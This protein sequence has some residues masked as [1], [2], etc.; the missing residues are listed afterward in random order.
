[1]PGRIAVALEMEPVDLGADPS[2]RAVAA[3]RQPVRDLGMLE[4]RVLLG[5][6]MLQA[7]EQERL[8]PV[9]VARVEARRHLQ[10]LLQRAPILD[11]LDAQRCRQDL[12]SA[13]SCHQAHKALGQRVEQC[14]GVFQIGGI[15]TLGEPAVDRREQVVGLGA[16]ALLGPQPGEARGGAQLP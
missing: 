8:H 13:S 1:M 16:L 6:Q 14:L 2:D 12:N 7:L 10:K 4:V 11:R 15:E 5:V 9:R 3:Q